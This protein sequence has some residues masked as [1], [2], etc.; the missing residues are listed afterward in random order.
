MKIILEWRSGQQEAISG[1]ELSQ[2]FGKLGLF[3]FDSVSL[4]DDHVTPVELLEH[5]LFPDDHFIRRDA[6]VPVSGHQN[7]ANERIL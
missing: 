7:V 2:K 4:V 6:H 5:G 3:I 1:F